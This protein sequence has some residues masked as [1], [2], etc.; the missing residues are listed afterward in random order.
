MIIRVRITDQK[1]N[2]GRLTHTDYCPASGNAACP[3]IPHDWPFSALPERVIQYPAANK[4]NKK[5]ML[6]PVI[7]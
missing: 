4:E 6:A 2:E 1:D 5:I 7:T 3:A